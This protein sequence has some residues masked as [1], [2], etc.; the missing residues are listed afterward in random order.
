MTSQERNIVSLTCSVLL[1]CDF[2]AAVDGGWSQW[3]D[4]SDCTANCGGGT[5]SQTR[6]CNNPLPANGGKPCSG[7]KEN[8]Q[9]C[10][11][12]KCSKFIT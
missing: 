6:E 10:N 9:A 1:C 4:W 12:K 11:K 5:R 7:L 8:K 2:F 3:S